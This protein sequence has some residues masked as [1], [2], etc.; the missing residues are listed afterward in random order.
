MSIASRN[1]GET[2]LTGRFCVLTTH[3][4]APEV[5]ETTV[6]TDLLQA[7]KVVTQLRVY[8]VREDLQV[9]AIDNVALTIQEPQGDL[10]LR[11]VLDDRHEPL[12]LVRVK[13]A[14]AGKP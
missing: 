11:R 10:E 9:L 14:R 13:L 12:Q 3:T 6:G 7:L 1:K 2:S 4:E 5:A 8:A